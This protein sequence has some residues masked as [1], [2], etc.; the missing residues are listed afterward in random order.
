LREK[1]EKEETERAAA[2]ER[3]E[4]ER[5]ASVAIGFDRNSIGGNS[6]Q[7]APQF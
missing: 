2:Q 7:N 1:K 4:R 6:Y 3:E 5:A